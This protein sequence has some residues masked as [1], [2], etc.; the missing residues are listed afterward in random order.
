MDLRLQTILQAA[1]RTGEAVKRRT[2]LI[3]Q[4]MLIYSVLLFC[5]FI[6]QTTPGFLELFGI[7]PLLVLP[8]VVSISMLEGEL[9][10]G[11]FGLAAGLLC[12]S[13]S[14]MLF[15]IN[16]ILYMVACV[17][18]GLLVIYYMQPSVWNSVLFA[19]I[20]LL[21]RELFEY[22]FYYVMWGY[23]GYYLVFAQR[24]LPMIL[25]TLAV[26]API[27]WSVKKIFEFYHKRI[28][29]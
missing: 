9:T 15:G 29:D 1:K 16:S 22:F 21:V 3:L 4:K 6:L 13:T 26:T 11:L 2:K 20:T 28:N 24:M 5:L 25:Y 7:K 27:Y 8:L 18:I 19:G 17:M 23:E 14:V 12:D 10:G